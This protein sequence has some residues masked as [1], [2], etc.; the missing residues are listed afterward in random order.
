MTYSEAQYETAN[1]LGIYLEEAD[2]DL[3]ALNTTPEYVVQDFLQWVRH[4]IKS[5]EKLAE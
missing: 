1:L 4:Q 5:A 3:S 2:I